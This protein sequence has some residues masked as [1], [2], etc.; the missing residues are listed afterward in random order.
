MFVQNSALQRQIKSVASQHG[1]A[2]RSDERSEVHIA[3]LVGR[4]MSRIVTQDEAEKRWSAEVRLLRQR[5]E[6]SA[7]MQSMV[8]DIKG[9]QTARQVSH[10]YFS[11]SHKLV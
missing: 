9:Q 1:G 11:V 10:S 7:V 8:Q 3:R 2:Q 4:L 5:L 6:R